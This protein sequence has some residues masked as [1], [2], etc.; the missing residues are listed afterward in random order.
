MSTWYSSAGFLQDLLGK[1]LAWLGLS[2]RAHNSFMKE[3]GV[4]VAPLTLHVGI[5]TFTPVRV[6]RLEEHRMHC[7]SYAIPDSA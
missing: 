3:A 2:H 4:E 6:E 1:Q 7:E 5:G